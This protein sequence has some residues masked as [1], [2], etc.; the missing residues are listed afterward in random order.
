MIIIIFNTLSVLFDVVD[1]CDIT[2]FK[3]YSMILYPFLYFVVQWFYSIEL[4]PNT[5]T[6]LRIYDQFT[7]NS[8]R[9]SI[10]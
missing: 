10:C 9:H 6:L 7:L 5:D 2:P 8:T 4:E 3:A 1:N